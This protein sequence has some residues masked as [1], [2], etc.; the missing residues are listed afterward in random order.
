MT[1]GERPHRATGAKGGRWHRL[2]TPR[3][4]YRVTFVMRYASGQHMTWSPIISAD[5]PDEAIDR[6]K[7][8]PRFLDTGTAEIVEILA[9][10]HLHDMAPFHGE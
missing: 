8:L 6:L 3:S 5:S 7:A 10:T 1:E 4:C 2:H 9:V